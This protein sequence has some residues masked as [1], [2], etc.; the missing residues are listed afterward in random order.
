MVSLVG[1]KLAQQSLDLNG[2]SVRPSIVRHGSVKVVPV[3]GAVVG[4][5]L[6]A[7]FLC[8][9]LAREKKNLFSIDIIAQWEYKS[10]VHFLYSQRLSFPTA[11]LQNLSSHQMNPNQTNES[12]LPPDRSFHNSNGRTPSP[13]FAKRIAASSTSSSSTAT[14]QQQQRHTATPTHHKTARAPTVSPTPTA[15]TTTTTTTTTDKKGDANSTTTDDNDNDV[16]TDPYESI[17]QDA[18]K[19]TRELESVCDE[20]YFYQ[21]QNAILLDQLT[22]AGAED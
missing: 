7:P 3:C 13:L 20:T 5:V 14:Q 22:M 4:N 9:L 10:G 18:A 2:G 11:R 16:N 8:L 6:L 12:M 1:V 21:V 19:W 15:N 17:L